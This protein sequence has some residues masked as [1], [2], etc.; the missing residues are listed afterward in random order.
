MALV[1]ERD[2]LLIVDEIQTGMGRT[3]AFWAHQRYNLKPDI[4]TCAKA[5]ANG[6][7]MGAM[8]AAD[9]AAQGFQPGAHATTFGGGP[10]VSAAAL[11]VLDIMEQENLVQRSLELGEMAVNEFKKLILSHPGK[12]LHVRGMGLMLGIE[13]NFPGQDV[14]KALLDKG[15]VCNLAQGRVLR[16]IPPLTIEKSDILDFAAALDEILAGLED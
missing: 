8:L 6:L 2:V 1:K 12:I 11:T 7:P 15:F 5:L 10:V 4:F 3:G 13:L 14:H 9:D 16:L